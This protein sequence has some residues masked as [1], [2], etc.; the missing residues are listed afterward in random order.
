MT[1]KNATGKRPD[2]IAYNVNQDRQGKGHFSRIGAAWSHKDG[3]GMDI[4]LD[5]TPVSGRLTLRE[6]RTEKIQPTHKLNSSKGEGY[7]K[8]NRES[9]DEHTR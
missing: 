1:D 5:A 7:L 4:Q 8:Q 6:L 9:S 3:Q 2:F